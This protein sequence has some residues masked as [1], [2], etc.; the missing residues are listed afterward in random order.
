MQKAIREK[1]ENMLTGL[2]AFSRGTYANNTGSRMGK[3]LLISKMI[4]YYRETNDT[5]NYFIRSVN[6]YDNYFMTILLIRSKE[7]IH[8]I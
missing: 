2:L 8:S 1:N 4:D 3:R 5:L 6:Y 7:E